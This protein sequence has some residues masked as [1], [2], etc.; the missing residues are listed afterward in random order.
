MVEVFLQ[1]RLKRWAEVEDL[2]EPVSQ[3]GGRL[4]VC[5]NDLTDEEVEHWHIFRVE[6][7]DQAGG[8]DGLARPRDAL[9]P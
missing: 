6:A 2:S 1:S 5:V 9:D 4:M 3:Q 7:P 8:V